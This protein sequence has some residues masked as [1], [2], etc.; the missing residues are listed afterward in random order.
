MPLVSLLG[1]PMACSR[2]SDK[3]SIRWLL[4][5]PLSIF[6][7]IFLFHFP[8]LRIFLGFLRLSL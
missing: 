6:E 4:R 8:D 3:A 7:T 5:E 1:V 2:S